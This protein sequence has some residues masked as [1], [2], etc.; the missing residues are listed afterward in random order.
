M[1][2]FD[3][4]FHQPVPALRTAPL[5]SFEPP[6]TPAGP[7]ADTAWASVAAGVLVVVVLFLG[8]SWLVGRARTT[9]RVRCPGG[10]ATS[11]APTTG[12]GA[13]PHDAAAQAAR[14][15]QGRGAAT[16]GQ[17]RV[18][19][20]LGALQHRHEI[21]Q[22]VLTDGMAKEFRDDH[23]PPVR[24]GNSIA[25]RVTQNGKDIGSPHCQRHV[26]TIAFGLPIAG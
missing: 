3:R 7:G 15:L 4:R 6:R 2:E 5:G 25:V 16:A 1:E 20:G 26:C 10:A 23:R 17:R 24:F 18:E 22:G 14:R 9:A 12:T 13:E 8:A 11:A 21:Y 19:L